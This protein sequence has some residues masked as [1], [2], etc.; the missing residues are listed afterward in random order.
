MPVVWLG[1]LGREVVAAE[2]PFDPESY[3]ALLRVDEA[4]ARAAFPEAFD[5]K[6]LWEGK[7]A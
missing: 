6:G 2:D 5:G 3:T 7:S 1:F 4:R